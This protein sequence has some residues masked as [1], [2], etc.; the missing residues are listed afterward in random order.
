MATLS[1]I[2]QGFGAWDGTADLSVKVVNGLLSQ[3]AVKV[4]HVTE[5]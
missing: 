5:S 2:S 4:L 3:S 1:E